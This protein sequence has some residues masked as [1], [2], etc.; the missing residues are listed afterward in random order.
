MILWSRRRLIFV[1]LT[2]LFFSIFPEPQLSAD[3]FS[4]L[5]EAEVEVRVTPGLT[6]TRVD[7]FEVKT[8]KGIR[9]ELQAGMT[10]FWYNK[11]EYSLRAGGGIQAAG[12]SSLDGGYTYSGFNSLY[13]G[14]LL[15]AAQKFSP[16][17][18]W[19]L[20]AGVLGEWTTQDNSK[21]LY[22]Y[23]ALR[24]EPGFNLHLHTTKSRGFRLLFHTGLPV[25]WSL[26]RDTALSLCGGLTLGLTFK[27]GGRS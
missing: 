24:L 7:G 18:E 23:P 20:Q 1:L 27:T 13:A 5:P 11:T 19:Q 10:L 2:V 14:L 16:K 15:G 12:A 8:Q 4:F 3:Q 25:E 17:A 22:F 26:R 6:I 21:Y 9:G